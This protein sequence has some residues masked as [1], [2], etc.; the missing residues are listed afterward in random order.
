MI[1]IKWLVVVILVLVLI[2]FI[3]FYL[4]GKESHKMT[5]NTGITNNA[6]QSCG[7]KPN[8]ASSNH[9]NPEFRVEQLTY[10]TSKKD[11]IKQLKSIGEELGG[12]LQLEE[13]NYLHFEFTSSIFKFTD[14]VEAYFPD[15]ESSIQLK[16]ASRVGHSDLGANKKRLLKII[17]AFQNNL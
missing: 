10:T 15:E 1:Y 9:I 5:P 11:A 17:E 12:S 14:D 8:C 4:L 13:E 16:S 6:L 2:V 7:T 3:K